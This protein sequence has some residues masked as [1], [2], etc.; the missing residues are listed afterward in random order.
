MARA[1][2]V[3]HD[4]LFLLQAF[5]LQRLC[6]PAKSQSGE[7]GEQIVPRDDSDWLAVPGD[8]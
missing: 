2:E 1:G 4:G 7:E 3:G 8:E 6:S 5:L